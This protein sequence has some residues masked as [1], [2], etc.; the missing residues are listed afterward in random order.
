MVQVASSPGAEATDADL[1]RVLR[2][3][4]IW[5]L[6]DRLPEGL[7]TVVGDRGYRLSGGERQRLA[8]ARLL[9]R[10]PDAGT[11]PPLDPGAGFRPGAGDVRGV[12]AP[13]RCS[14]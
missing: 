2:Q 1:E 9:L 13:C 3:A 11:G 14:Q 7:E 12:L 6:V 10:A 4:R 8:I 5:D